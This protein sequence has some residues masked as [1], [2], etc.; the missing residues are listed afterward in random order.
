LGKQFSLT[1]AD[2]FRLGAYRADPTGTAKGGV[3]GIQ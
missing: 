1:S 3:V 2:S